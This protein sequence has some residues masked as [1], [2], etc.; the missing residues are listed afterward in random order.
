MS[1]EKQ[2]REEQAVAS[3]E[4][5]IVETREMFEQVQ[6]DLREWN[7]ISMIE[8]YEVKKKALK[9]AAADMM[10]RFDLERERR[11]L[12]GKLQKLSIERFMRIKKMKQAAALALREAEGRCCP[13]CGQVVLDEE[14]I[15]VLDQMEDEA[16]AAKQH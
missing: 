5:S 4:K 7:M 14:T 16:A 10:S 1:T 9:A 11:L 13:N 3:L 2:A 12:E 8:D 15:Q 6:E